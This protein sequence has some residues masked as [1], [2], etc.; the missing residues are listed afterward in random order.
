MSSP[1]VA[2]VGIGRWGKNLLRCFD[3]RTGVV[4]CHHTGDRRNAAWVADR[5]PSVD[6][7]TDYDDVLDDPRVDAV[8]VATPIDT[9]ADLAR[10]ALAADKHVFV[11]KPLAGTAADAADLVALA[12]RRDRVLFVGYVFVHNP[13]IRE[14]ETAVGGDSIRH[15]RF[16][17]E[18]F[19]PFDEG[20]V[21][22][23]VSHDVSLLRYLFDARIDG[24]QVREAEG[25][26]D[27]TDVLSL[28]GSLGDGTA[29]SIH[30]NRI[31]RIDRKAITVL[32]DAGECLLF[33]DDRLFRLGPEEYDPVPVADVEPLGAE[34]EAFLE[35]VETGRTSVTDGAFGHEVDQVLDSI[36]D[37]VA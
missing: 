31:S 2:V 14:L 20:I 8:V 10:R 9:H 23:L 19:G 27:R 33:E 24:F 35:C 15:V 21:R 30:A 34:C 17:W 12:D 28:D 5:Y 16:D 11:E 26:D 29:F 36:V 6:V 18:K 13:A 37:R 22:N 3:E 25:V 4:A 32:T 7:T 1:A